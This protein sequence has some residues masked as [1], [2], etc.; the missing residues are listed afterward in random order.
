[1]SMSDQEL[2]EIRP[3]IHQ[4]A[5][6]LNAA[7]AKP[8]AALAMACEL[9]ALIYSPVLVEALRQA[10]DAIEQKDENAR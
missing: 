3:V 1:M 5:A 6:M 7:G 4:H 10:E 2:E 8:I 9:A